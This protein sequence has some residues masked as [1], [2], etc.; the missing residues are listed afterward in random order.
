MKPCGNS[1]DGYAFPIEL[2]D[3]RPLHIGERPLRAL[4]R[5][6]RFGNPGIADPV[7]TPQRRYRR[8]GPV[9]GKKL[10]GEGRTFPLT[11]L[12]AGRAYAVPISTGK[13]LPG[14]AHTADADPQ[15]GRNGRRLTPV[16]QRCE[17]AFAPPARSAGAET[18]AAAAMITARQKPASRMPLA[19]RLTARIAGSTVLMRRQSGDGGI[20]DL[21][22]RTRMR[23]C[24]KMF[25]KLGGAAA[26]DA[27]PPV[28]PFVRNVGNLQAP[29]ALTGTLEASRPTDFRAAL[30][31]GIEADA[32]TGR[33]V[34]APQEPG[35]RM[36]P[37]T[38]TEAVAIVPLGTLVERQQSHLCGAQT[39]GG[40]PPGTHWPAGM[41]SDVERMR[42]AFVMT[43][44]RLR[45]AFE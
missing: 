41:T 35:R 32:A 43:A 42:T 7:P 38:K 37:A 33:R 11:T 1:L 12:S 45:S 15:A 28:T 6:D 16:E 13:R 19:E 10:G 30:P 31:A 3:Q 24:R 34:S 23:A 18:A 29:I 27:E 17:D 39:V 14:H 21:G 36:G 4:S 8:S 20:E 22:Q 2:A 5:R 9:V 40:R 26:M 25:L 44:A